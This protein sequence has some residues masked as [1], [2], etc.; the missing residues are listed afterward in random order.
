MVRP[1]VHEFGPGI[2]FDDGVVRPE[3][4]SNWLPAPNGPLYL[5]LRN[6]APDPEL[7]KAL[8]N[9]DTFVGPPPVLPTK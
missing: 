6:Y 3:R 1:A 5:I 2:A 7:G 9:I 8:V 4:E